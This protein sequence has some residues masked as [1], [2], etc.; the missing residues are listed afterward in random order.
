M[1]FVGVG[2]FLF[3]DSV[4]ARLSFLQEA[5]SIWR[6]S[7][8]SYPVYAVLEKKMSVLVSF[9]DRFLFFTMVLWLKRILGLTETLTYVP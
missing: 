4:N 3:S 6:E 8:K 2:I 1:G 9:L 7:F 5:F